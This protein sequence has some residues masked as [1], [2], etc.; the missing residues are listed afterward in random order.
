MSSPKIP[1]SVRYA[2]E[3]NRGFTDSVKREIRMSRSS[4]EKLKAL[5]VEWGTSGLGEVIALLLAMHGRKP[6]K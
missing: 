5:A 3:T 4:A 2:R 1:E 6:K